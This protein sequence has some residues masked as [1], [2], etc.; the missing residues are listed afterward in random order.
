MT[1]FWE[2]QGIMYPMMEKAYG[3]EMDAMSARNAMPEI[4]TGE[5]TI[6]STVSITYEIK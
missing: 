2:D 3:G 4:P 6:K 1:S 5:N